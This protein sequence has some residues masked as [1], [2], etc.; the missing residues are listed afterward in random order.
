M[1]ESLNKYRE[2]RHKCEVV[3]D[4]GGY[5]LANGEMNPAIVDRFVEFLSDHEAKVTWEPFANPDGRT[6][7]PFKEAGIRLIAFSL[8]SGHPDIVVMD[9]TIYGP[10]EY[11]PTAWAVDGVL[12][13][14]PYFG[15]APL[16][17][18]EGE[19][20]LVDSEEKWKEKLQTAA[21]VAMHYCSD[22]AHICAVGRR[23]RHGGKEIK[24]DEWLVAVFS[25]MEVV[26]VWESQPDIA[27]I[28]RF[29]KQ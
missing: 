29:K 2:L 12:F 7:P 5:N 19:L 11:D 18:E 22:D 1:S 25:D 15:S 9:S 4:N 26:E 14:P 28:L 13:H 27:I 24:L 23:Y 8:T 10:A 20:S 3:A 16:S 17:E 6:F 21:D